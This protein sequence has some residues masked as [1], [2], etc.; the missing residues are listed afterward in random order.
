MIVRVGEL[1][2]EK[3]NQQKTCQHGQGEGDVDDRHVVQGKAVVTEGLE[4]LSAVGGEAVDGD[5]GDP[6]DERQTK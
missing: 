3:Q 1:L 6:G 4:D 2:L 5:V